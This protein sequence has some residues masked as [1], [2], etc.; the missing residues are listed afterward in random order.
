[1][2]LILFYE[3]SAYYVKSYASTRH[4]KGSHAEFGNNTVQ[5]NFFNMAEQLRQARVLMLTG[6]LKEMWI[7]IH[8]VGSEHPRIL[9]SEVADF[10]ITIF[11][12]VVLPNLL[13]GV[14]PCMDFRR[15]TVL[16]ATSH[17][18]LRKFT[19][20]IHGAHA[21][22]TLIPDSPYH[23]DSFLNKWMQQQDTISNIQCASLEVSIV[24]VGAEL[25]NLEVPTK[26]KGKAIPGKPGRFKNRSKPLKSLELLRL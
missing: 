19:V 15:R 2:F 18:R 16:L 9:I 23:R 8:R 21:R 1:M 12:M 4:P 6:I 24:E 25:A 17:I 26:S 5:R 11:L 20:I 13:Y 14:L 10:Q 3:V 22:K 7:L